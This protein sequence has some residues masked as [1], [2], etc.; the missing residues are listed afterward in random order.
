M[1]LKCG[2]I[3]R[4]ISKAEREDYPEEASFILD[5]ACD[6]HQKEMEEKKLKLPIPN[7]V[8]PGV[9]PKVA[10]VDNYILEYTGK[11][12]VKSVNT[13]KVLGEVEIPKD[14]P[15]RQRFNISSQVMQG[16]TDFMDKITARL[17]ALYGELDKEKVKEFMGLMTSVGEQIV[18]PGEM[19]KAEKVVVK[20]AKKH[21]KKK[22]EKH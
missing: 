11:V 3:I 7:N 19:Q 6:K 2:C 21:T 10:E 18:K 13:G 22:K 12:R 15:L 1:K 20:E 9:L 16:A 14:H 8:L 17:Q 5:K 4:K